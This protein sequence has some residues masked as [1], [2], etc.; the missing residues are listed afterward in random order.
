M[1]K[2]HDNHQF[3]I[4]T[5]TTERH[6]DIELR[7]AIQ[8]DGPV[9][10]CV[11]GWPELWYSW[12]HQM[13]Y[14][15][16]RGYRVVAM[17]V[18]G[19]G[20]SSKPHPISAY[21]MRELAS[22]VAAVAQ[23][24]SDEPVILFGHDWGAPIVYNTALLHP[25]T[26]RAVA[27]LS[28]PF[29][30]QGEGSMLDLMRQLYAGK[31]F[32]QLYFQA[33][34]VVEAE[35]EADF[36]AALEKIYFSLSGDAPLDHFIRERAPTQTLLEGTVVPSPFPEWMQPADLTV[37]VDAFTAGG[38][39]GPINRY[40]AQVHDPEQLASI[41]GSTIVQPACFIGGERDA[42]RH[43]IPGGDL[44]ADP[45]AAL[46]DF[47]GATLIHGVGH[48]VQQEAP[49]QTNQALEAFVQGL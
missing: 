36:S 30:P 23:H 31:F 17:D 33:E 32:Y 4:V 25:E 46:V 10:L 9:I 18:R 1:S 40:R 45:G 24:I 3:D 42:V 38:F 22:D 19:Y 34:G 41:R 37:Y 21:T 13:T 11:H 6:G 14:F 29:M 39:R 48:W 2:G 7:V 8:G 5:H 49:A 28:V 20:G 26:I 27:G 12:R 15:A 16:Q 35:V 43:F 47:R 44:Y